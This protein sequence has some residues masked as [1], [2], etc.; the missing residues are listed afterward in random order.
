MMI[1]KGNRK[2]KKINFS[3]LGRRIDKNAGEA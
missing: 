2:R 3:W 1:K